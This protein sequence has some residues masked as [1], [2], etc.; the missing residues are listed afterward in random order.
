MNFS[1]SYKTSSIS[2][3][4]IKTYQNNKQ[5]GR[6][7]NIIEREQSSDKYNPDPA[8]QNTKKEIVS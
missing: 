2:N 5:A 4:S 1:L 7:F 8:N 6:G 3:T